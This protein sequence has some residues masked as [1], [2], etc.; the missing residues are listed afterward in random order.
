MQ[1]P[2]NMTQSAEVYQSVSDIDHVL[3]R[4]DMYIN[5]LERT[6]RIAKCLNPSEMKI[7]QKTVTLPEGQEQC[8]VE[9]IGNA[10]D[11]VWESREKGIDSGHI[12]VTVNAEWFIVKNYGLAIP[13][14][15]NVNGRWIPEAIFGNLRSSSKYDDSK[16]RYLI[17]KNGLGAKLVSVYSRCFTIECADAQRGLLYRQNWQNNMKLMGDPNI[18]QY[19]GPGY[20]QVSVSL[21]FVRFGTSG[22]DQEALE[23]YA[24]HCAAVSYTCQVPVIFNGQKFEIKDLFTYAGL[25]YPVN[26]ASAITYRDPDGAYDLCIIDTPDSGEQG[27]VCAVNASFVNGIV[28]TLGGCHVDA[29]YKVVVQA[30]IDFMGKSAEGVSITKRDVVN[31]ISLFISCRINNPK[32]TSQIKDNLKS[33]TPKIELPENLLKGIKKWRLIQTIIEEIERKQKNKMK[34]NDGKKK[35]RPRTDDSF[36]ANLAGGKRSMETTL[37]L[38]EGKS[39]DSYPLKFISQIPNGMGREFFGRLPLHGKILN[40]LNADFLQIYEHKDIDAIRQNLGL[41]TDVDYSLDENYRKLNYGSLLIMPDADNDGKHI[42]G[43]VLLFFLQY[44]P[45]LV[46]RGFVKFLRIPVVRIKING[47]DLSFYS[48]TSFKIFMSRLPANSQVGE[49][50]HFKG[51]GSSEDHHIK[52]DFANPKIVTFRICD[53]TGEKIM[54]A[55]HKTASHLRKQWIADWVNRVVTDTDDWTDLPISVFI[56]HEFIDYSIENNIRGLPEAI[57]GLKESQR[58]ALYAAMKKLKGKKSKVKV[59]QVANHAAEITNYKHGEGCLADTIVQMT[60]NFVSSNNMPYFY[61]KGQFGCFDPL[62][63]VL[64]WTGY[65]KLAKDI[66]TEDIL[67]GDDGQPRHISKIVGGVDTM[68]NVIQEYGEIYKVNSQHI[69]TVQYPEHR[70]IYWNENKWQMKYYDIN[71]KKIK[72]FSSDN[73]DQVIEFS[74][75]LSTSNILDINIQTYLSLPKEHQALFKNVYNFTDIKWSKQNAPIDP[76]TYGCQIGND[77]IDDIYIINDQ[78]TR[79]KLLSGI[80]DTYG[81][82]ECPRFFVDKVHIDSVTFLAKSLGFKVEIFDGVLCITINTF[83]KG[84]AIQVEIADIGPYVGWYLDGNER[85]LHGDFTCLHNTRGAGG[86]DAANP[87]YTCI[88]LPWWTHVVFRPEDKRLEKLIEDEGE[89]QECEN[90]F[91]TLPMHLINGVVGIATAYSTN[92]PNHHPLDIAFWLQQRNLQDLQPEANHQLPLIKP[93]YKGFKGQIIPTPNGFITEGIMTVNYDQSVTITELPIGMWTN[94]YEKKLHEWEEAGIISGFD[95]YCTDTDIKFI[96][97]KYLDGVPTL[98]NLKLISKHSYNNMTVLYRTAD[99]GIQPKIYNN[100]PELIE[101]FYKLRIAKYV[102]RKFLMLLEFDRDIHDL[103]EKARYIHAV[104]VDQSLEV[105]NRPERE[106]LAD[107]DRMGFA[108]D[109]LDKVKTRALNKDQIPL[110]LKKIQAK[111]DEK[112]YLETIQEQATYY[113]ELE[114]F[115]VKYC[116]EEKCTRSTMDSCNPVM[117]LTIGDMTPKS[118]KKA[119]K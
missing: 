60:Y 78:D 9:I 6:P 36:P 18:I 42:M 63:P 100:V 27:K 8:F 103:S 11:N 28:T 64:L 20:T 44:Y 49:A 94:T 76:Y 97:P 87:R 113:N 22:Y 7:V 73:K 104:A 105:R 62:T 5:A 66:T 69:L 80:I 95:T 79:M 47:Q 81:R 75:N 85:F 51:L 99:R 45:G 111:R 67:V 13:V 53:K 14:D 74:Q 23:V 88:S 112:A 61:P 77:K 30:I 55:F 16:P 108:H 1:T 4:P 57:D 29:A 32:F 89:A 116:K 56:D 119:A 35:K 31:H 17:G 90:L 41:K 83:F 86:E 59:A 106:I 114:E 3:L 118:N 15:R 26:R 71:D 102:E 38:T 2:Q 107:M 96:I 19:S 33:P 25:F 70:L 54:L 65:I 117:T 48:M 34:K 109:L 39:A 115:I 50:D 82:K 98:K 110:L 84:S 43:L 92:I 24:G 52:Q 58:K 93:Y 10:A 68:Y 40:V 72:S 37:I 46:Q 21:D 91:P 12:E 101:D